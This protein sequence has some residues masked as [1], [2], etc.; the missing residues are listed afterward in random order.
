VS[1]HRASHCAEALGTFI[2]GQVTVEGVEM[3]ILKKEIG[4]LKTELAGVEHQDVRVVPIFVTSLLRLR[5]RKFVTLM[6]NCESSLFQ[7]IFGK[8]RHLGQFFGKSRHFDQI[9]GK[10]RHFRVRVGEVLCLIRITE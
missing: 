4:I 6:K 10:V 2:L 8:A 9:F 7:Q 3:G 5:M 1:A